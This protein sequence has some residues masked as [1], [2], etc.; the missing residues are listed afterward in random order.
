MGMGFARTWLRQVS[1]P[2]LH[3]TTL[4]TGCGRNLRTKLY[5]AINSLSA[6]HAY[7]KTLSSRFFRHWSTDS[8]LVLEL[9]LR[10]VITL[11]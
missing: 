7:L 11:T 5:T 6:K 9:W 1:P 8:R 3:V 2:L 4:T 10:D